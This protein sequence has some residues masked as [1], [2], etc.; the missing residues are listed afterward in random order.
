MPRDTVVCSMHGWEHSIRDHFWQV[1]NGNQQDASFE[2]T[3]PLYIGCSHM[4]AFLNKWLCAGKRLFLLHIL[5]TYQLTSCLSEGVSKNILQHY[6]FII[7][8][9]LEMIAQLQLCS[10]FLLTIIVPMCWLASHTFKLAHCNW[11]EKWMERVIELVY[12]AFVAIQADGMLILDYDFMIGIFVDLQK[13]LPDFNTN[14]T[15]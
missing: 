2:A 8:E 14:M 6:L 11:G 12:N 15:W 10:V 7:Y 5:N 3:F 9:S 4:V 1:L 13:K